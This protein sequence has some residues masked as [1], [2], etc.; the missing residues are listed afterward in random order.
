MDSR[1]NTRGG[2]RSRGRRQ[3][4]ARAP[5]AFEYVN[6]NV[7]V[8]PPTVKSNPK[9]FVTAV[10]NLEAGAPGTPVTISGADLNGQLLEQLGYTPS[11]VVPLKI[12]AWAA[13]VS[14]VNLKLSRVRSSVA[15]ITGIDNGSFSQRAKVAIT[16][17]P[18]KQ[19]VIGLA[20]AVAMVEC[21]QAVVV[22]I[23]CMTWGQ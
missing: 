2:P 13:G 23:S 8:D 16:I 17:P 9:R 7:P 18:L 6:L 21:T 14:E 20:S 3:T 11:N 22:H 5:I 12:S 10:L 15:Y 1:R 4:T 19:E